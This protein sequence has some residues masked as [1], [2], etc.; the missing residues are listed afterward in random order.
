MPK[1]IYPLVV[2][3][4][5]NILVG[6]KDDILKSTNYINDDVI[7]HQY[8][9]QIKQKIDLQFED[10]PLPLCTYFVII[11]TFYIIFPDSAE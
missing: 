5:L 3:Y 1:V 11:F 7:F 4:I 6:S 8:K 10:N 9:K 2:N